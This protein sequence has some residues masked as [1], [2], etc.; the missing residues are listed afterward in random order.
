MVMAEIR[1]WACKNRYRRVQLVGG[2]GRGARDTRPR[3]VRLNPPRGRCSG[4]PLASP[5]AMRESPPPHVFEPL[6]P[7]TKLG[8]R[9]RVVRSRS[10][11]R[12]DRSLNQPS[13]ISILNMSEV[14]LGDVRVVSPASSAVILERRSGDPHITTKPSRRLQSLDRDPASTGV[15]P[16]TSAPLLPRESKPWERPR[17][18]WSEAPSSSSGAC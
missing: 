16:S 3:V 1:L 4:E 7:A 17:E 12:S 13:G 10:S 15:P 11:E 14:R 18:S 8:R 5:V 9:L 6:L 2:G